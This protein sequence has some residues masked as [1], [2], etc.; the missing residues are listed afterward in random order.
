[1]LLVNGCG[2]LVVGCVLLVVGCVLLVVC[3][4][5]LVVGCVLWV[6]HGVIKFINYKSMLLMEWN[7]G[8]GLQ[9]IMWLCIII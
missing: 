5:L 3:F 9:W 7:G 6:E 1:M 2:Q 4:V 8:R